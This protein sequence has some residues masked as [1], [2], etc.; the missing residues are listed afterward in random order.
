MKLYI[1]IS[2]TTLFTIS[3]CSPSS[4]NVI[5]IENTLNIERIDE[6]VRIP[7]AKFDTHIIDIK[8][9][10]ILAIYNQNKEFI[11]F[12]LE[13]IDNDK[14]WDQLIFVTDFK[15]KEIKKI[16]FDVIER[17]K[18]P[19]VSKATD[20]HFGVGSNSRDVTEVKNYKRNGDPRN[21]A[22]KKFFQMEGPAWEND[23]VGFRMY[24]DPRNGIDIFGKTT[25][26]LVLSQVGINGDYH[27]K[28]T[29]GMDILKVGNSLGAG[30]IAI[31]LNDSLY[32]IT[33]KNGAR[34]KVIEEGPIKASFE[35]NYINDTIH[36]IPI[37]V[38]H[39]I[40]IY[41]G[42]WYYKS[43]VSLSG[44]TQEM[45]LV[46]G[47]VNLK[48]NQLY[49]KERNSLFSLYSHGKQSENGDHLGMAL[50]LNKDLYHTHKTITKKENGITN[51][52]YVVFNTENN[53]TIPFYFLSG[54][55]ASSQKF[56]KPEGFTQKI[57]ETLDQLSHPI[58]IK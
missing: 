20:I 49:I 28:E 34:Y 5:T 33:G 14:K 44:I 40:S 43:E 31:Q 2:L 26:D 58:I 47:I 19:I 17:E 10:S 16:Y 7:I 1:L 54:W 51:T 8:D 25:E 52:H 12:Q 37:Q 13:D 39:K 29:W 24:F 45:K 57:A 56:A 46:A 36:G 9:E 50:L 38:R 11:P 55:E 48:P 42:Q 35:M 21:A 23:K 3:G 15:P 6:L 22:D 30:S 4:K 18:T 53:T 41:K 32:R 27:T